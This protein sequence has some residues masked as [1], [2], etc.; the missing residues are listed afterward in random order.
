MPDGPTADLLSRLQA[1][2]RVRRYDLE[3]RELIQAVSRSLSSTLNLPASLARLC[4]SAAPLFGAGRAAAWIHD[5]RARELV[6][7]A[8]SDPVSPE[9]LRM[10]LVPAESPIVAALRRDRPEFITLGGVRALAVPLRGRRRAL[11]L[12]LFERLGPEPVPLP[13]LLAGAAEL[14]RHLSSAI[15]N[16]VLF[17]DVLR[18]RRELENTFNSLADLVIVCDPDLRVANANRAFRHRVAATGGDAKDRRVTELVGAELA[19]WLRALD[20]TAPTAPRE[21]ALE[22]TDPVLDG[23]FSVRV[24]PLHAERGVLGLVIVARDR[25]EQVKLESERAALGERLAQSEKLAALGQFVAGVAHELNNP[26][27]GVLG[28]MDLLRA[29]GRVPRA[30]QPELRLILREAERAAKIVNNLLVFAGSR[31]GTHRRVSLNS[32]VTRSA[33]LRARP[34]RS[35]G[36]AIARELDRTLPRVRGDAT[37]LQQAM[38]NIIANAEHA[39]VAAGV[40]DGRIRIVTRTERD[41]ALAAVE[42]SDNGRGIAP[43]LLPRVFEPFFTTKEVG[44][45]TGLGL[46]IVYGIVHDHGGEISAGAAS[47]GGAVFRLT[48]PADT[49]GSVPVRSR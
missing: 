27:Q 21:R 2:E 42:I 12:L 13:D 17:E 31:R 15:E 11:G 39:I 46:A 16:T 45:G 40:A 14:G 18:S 47:D 9:V 1:L 29:T 24:T 43:E 35:H 3:L 37:L 5:R 7:E 33:A 4:H 20:F 41:G 32:I 8:S 19:A 36:I 34:A 48:F 6:L 30:I 49:M 23:H 44:Q 38:L 26:L 22:I 25:T 28:H 10:P